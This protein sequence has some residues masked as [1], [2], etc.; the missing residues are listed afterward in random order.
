VA[1]LV[2]R[3]RCDNK[4]VPRKKF[5][6]LTRLQGVRVAQRLLNP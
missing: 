6:N 1:R 5:V 3:K 2:R 4:D